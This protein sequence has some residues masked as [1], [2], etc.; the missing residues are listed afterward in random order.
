MTGMERSE[1]LERVCQCIAQV[2]NLDAAT[3]SEEQKLVDDLGAD[4]LD[5]L[6][7]TFRLQ[8]EFKVT[9]SPPS[10]NQP[11]TAG[12]ISRSDMNETSMLANMI[13]SGRLSR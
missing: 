6:D 13:R 3:I 4:S 7:L 5:L 8:Q 2:L 10:A 9:I 11:C 1:I 12:S